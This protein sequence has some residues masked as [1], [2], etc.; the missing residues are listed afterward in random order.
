MS[1]YAMFRFNY[2]RS[3]VSCVGVENSV[4]LDSSSKEHKLS[5]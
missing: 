4:Q 5:N 3:A 1:Q 2:T